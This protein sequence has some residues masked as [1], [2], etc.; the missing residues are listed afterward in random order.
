VDLVITNQVMEHVKD[1]FWKLHNVSKV[2][3]VGGH[4]IIGVPNL[5]SLHNRV[6]LAFGRQPT[7]IGNHSAHI[8]GYTRQDMVRLFSLACPAGYELVDCRGGGFYPFGPLF[9]IPLAKLFPSNAVGMFLLFRKIKEY[10]SS[11]ID[12]PVVERLNTN[13]YTGQDKS[14]LWE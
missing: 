13:F 10:D 7:S 4:L 12:Y 8:R 1:I 14:S 11:F 2:L 9:A 3:K 5:A 6:L